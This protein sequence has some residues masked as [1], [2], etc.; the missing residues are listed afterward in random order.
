MKLILYG[1]L[2]HHKN[3]IG[4][5]LM[6]EACEIN[7]EHTADQKEIENR[8]DYDILFCTSIYI[9][10]QLIPQNVKIVF[11]PQFWIFP[12]PPIAGKRD[13]SCEKRCVYNILSEW[14]LNICYEFYPEFKFE[15]KCFPFAV[16]IER[17][18]PSVPSSGEIEQQNKDLVLVYIKRKRNSIIQRTLEVLKNKGINYECFTY[19]S[20]SEEYYIEMLKRSKY[21]ISLDAHESQGFALEEAMS[22][23]VPLLV[24][25]AE[26]MYEEMNPDGCSSAYEY[27]R[28]SG[29]KLF[30]TSV[31]YWDDELC[32]LKI[33][34]EEAIEEAI[35]RMNQNYYKFNPREYIL[36][37]LSPK[38]CMQRILNYF[39]L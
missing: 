32:G 1:P 6:C 38:I 21:M 28:P 19:G 3:L 24:V 11:G 9:D 22:C 18:A 17:F 8:N 7:F 13:L 4:L 33:T 16:D 39:E 15:L 29:K 36:K 2:P 12:E 34:S 30:S 27:L 37:T 10:P 25:D 14:V 31:P 5:K 23:G 20:Y 26:S 35:E